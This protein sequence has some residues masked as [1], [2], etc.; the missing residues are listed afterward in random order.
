M[1]VFTSYL[2]LFHF[3]VVP[4]FITTLHS[5]GSVYYYIQY[6]SIHIYLYNYTVS[7]LVMRA[8]VCNYNLYDII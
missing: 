1:E 6:Y 8:K 4:G 3:A 7:F 5:C 2:F